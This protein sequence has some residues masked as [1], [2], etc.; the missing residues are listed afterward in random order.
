MLQV[1]EASIYSLNYRRAGP[2]YLRV[3]KAVRYRRSSVNKWLADK[4]TATWH[5]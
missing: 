1:T 2:P 4:E 3:G 5:P